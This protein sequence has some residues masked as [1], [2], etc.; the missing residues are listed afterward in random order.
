[1]KP[2]LS[3]IKT[4]NIKLTVN[5]KVVFSKAKERKQPNATEILKRLEKGNFAK[6]G[7][8]EKK[9]TEKK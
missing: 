4:S 2:K 7:S 5:G 6:I 1:V 9:T 3:V 8:A